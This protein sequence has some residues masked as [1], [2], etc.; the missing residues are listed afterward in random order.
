MSP[1][2][3]MFVCIIKNKS[4]LRMADI[5]KM[6]NICADDRSTPNTD[7]PILTKHRLLA[8]LKSCVKIFTPQTWKTGIMPFTC[9]LQH[10]SFLNL[11]ENTTNC[12]RR[13]CQIFMLFQSHKLCLYIPS[14]LSRNPQAKFLE[15]H[16]D[17]AP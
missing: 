1:V 8:F 15:L 13:F 2:N 4:V 10:C 9:C 3:S 16:S 11:Y 17:K 5:G 14:L 7:G 12:H 6:L